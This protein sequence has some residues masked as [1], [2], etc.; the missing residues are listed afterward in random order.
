M[1]K[2]KLVGLSRMGKAHGLYVTAVKINDNNYA[3]GQGII[4]NDESTYDNLTLDE[5]T[6]K[7][8]LTAEK[9]K[10][11]PYV[12]DPFEIYHFPSGF[13]FDLGLEEHKAFVDLIKMSANRVAHSK[14]KIKR[15]T[16][17]FYLQNIELESK[18][19]VDTF[20]KIIDAG[21]II[22]DLGYDDA[23]TLLGFVS[24]TTGDKDIIGK[25][26]SRNAVMKS[27]ADYAQKRPSII[28][29]AVKPENKI[30]MKV[31]KLV[32]EGIIKSKRGD[33][34]E[35]NTFIASD[36]KGLANVYRND[37][38]LRL[39]WEKKLGAI[40]NKEVSF[41]AEPKDKE[42]IESK[43]KVEILIDEYKD[44]LL[45]IEIEKARIIKEELEKLNDER[46]N[47]VLKE[48]KV[49]ADT[50]FSKTEETKGQDGDAGSKK[51]ENRNKGFTSEVAKLFDLGVA[52]GDIIQN[53]NWYKIKGKSYGP[54]KG[55]AVDA[56]VA[57]GRDEALRL[58]DFP[59]EISNN[60]MI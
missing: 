31:S 58:L 55:K 53:G 37:S 40:Q 20:N 25:K 51:S 23:Y 8:P 47:K 35:G 59:K 49:I 24:V 13:E 16:H 45:K 14:N 54:S 41:A 44:S 56:I 43:T 4:P 52:N 36:F 10:K 33:F 46:A 3:T 2:I 26:L 50:L 15:G 28:I 18:E 7:K 34:Y 9:A 39:R 17:D 57:L 48:Y 5:M 29:E 42:I 38:E 32:M 21:N 19:E 22:R 11:F 6:G 60:Q 27:L 12:I 30:L 1:T